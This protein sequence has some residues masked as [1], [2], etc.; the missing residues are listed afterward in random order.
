MSELE[1]DQ[2][3]L[4]NGRNIYLI[5]FMGAG[6]STLAEYLNQNYGLQ[7]VEM[8]QVIEEQE[9]KTVSDIFAAEG[10]AYF[11]A[12]ETGLLHSL[13]ERDHL[14]VSCGGGAALREEN[15]A[16]MKRGGRVILL[17][18]SPE[19]IY[20]RVKDCEDR[21][22]LMGRNDVQG[23]ADLMEQRRGRY[24]AAADLVISTDRK[25][26]EEICGEL[27]HGLACM[28]S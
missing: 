28:E 11:R 5:G 15:V 14:V 21:P 17:T 9:G 27:L 1:R 23:I 10:E 8:D 7:V 16:E 12:R 4:E 3:V 25:T 6:K 18:A 20:A 24:E 22:L 13:A 2:K 19:E 26:E